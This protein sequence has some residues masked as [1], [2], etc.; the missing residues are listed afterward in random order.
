VFH[1]Q[2]REEIEYLKLMAI[3][4]AIITAGNKIAAAVTSSEFTGSDS[5]NKL[6]DIIKEQMMPQ[7]K[8]ALEERARKIKEM[9]EKEVAG[10][11]IQVQ[12]VG[13][14]KRNDGRR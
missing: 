8:E 3:V 10:G 5:L 2:R 7:N 1:I 6:L 9:L 14:G 12:V 11:P 13:K 4:N